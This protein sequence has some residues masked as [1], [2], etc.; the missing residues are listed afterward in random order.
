M[1]FMKHSLYKWFSET[2]V[3]VDT[4]LL[5]EWFDGKHIPIKGK[6]DHYDLNCGDHITK[7]VTAH[8]FV[9]N[10]T[11]EKCREFLGQIKITCYEQILEIY[12]REKHKKAKKRNLIRF[13][14]DGFEN[15]KNAW[16]ALFRVVTKLT[17]GI[18]IKAKIAG[19]EFLWISISSLKE[20]LQQKPQRY[21]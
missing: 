9:E 19:L 21:V 2:Q 3:I 14:C 10:R 18:P 16:S 20:R 17:F 1:F 15:Y 6:E 12:K 4:I 13:V 5:N 11:L 7:C 8:L